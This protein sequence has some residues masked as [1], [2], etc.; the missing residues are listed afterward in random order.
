MTTIEVQ[1]WI[2][3][4]I[5]RLRDTSET[6]FMEA[7]V[8][9]TKVTGQ[10]REW[11]ALHPEACL[12]VAQIEELDELLDR[13]SKG[14][15]LAYLTGTRSFFGFDF[16]VTP[17]VLIPRP[18]TEQLVEECIAWLEA[19]PTRRRMA[20]V[21]TGSGIIAI[22]VADRFPDLAVDA[23]DV[24][25]AA[26][27]IAKTN[28]EKHP[29]AQQIHF[30]LNNLLEG[31]NHQ[32]DMI[33]ANLPYIPTNTLESLA[34]TR[35]EPRLA[36]DGGPDGLDLLRRLIT[37]AV[38]RL[39]VGGLMILEIESRQGDACAMIA[40]SIFPGAEI[41]LLHDLANLPRIIKIQK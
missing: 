6:P 30:D 32:Y 5:T 34:V 40:R 13:L 3:Q 28:A 29:C 14:E 24:S 37:Q 20:D 11:L 22:C 36:L 25:E 23:F 27:E 31:V 18:E 4:S 38:D 16:C 8:L 7:R 35:Y 17:D 19:H 10:S 41:R 1:D 33:A 2:K 21:G 12:D 9:V 39:A 26:L 15:P